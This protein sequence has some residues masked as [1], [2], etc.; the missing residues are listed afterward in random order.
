MKVIDDWKKAWRFLSV[1]LSALWTTLT[2]VWLITPEDQRAAILT[3]IGIDAA[4]RV[5]AGFVL[6]VVARLKAQPTLHE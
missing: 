6:V 2:A 5:V 3:A 1:Q 4:W